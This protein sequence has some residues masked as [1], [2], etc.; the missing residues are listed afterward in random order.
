MPMTWAPPALSFPIWDVGQDSTV[1]WT[2][3]CTTNMAVPPVPWHPSHM[4]Q[5]ETVQ[6]TYTHV[7]LYELVMGNMFTQQTCL[8]Y[9]Y[10]LICLHSEAAAFTQIQFIEECAHY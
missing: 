9:R 8:E 1:P 4:G 6:W 7:L 10:F 2:C 5:D 3:T